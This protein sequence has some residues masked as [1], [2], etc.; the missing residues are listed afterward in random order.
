[1]HIKDQHGGLIAFDQPG[2]DHPGQEGLAGAGCAEDAGRALDE[3]VQVEAHRVPL[4]EGVADAEEAFFAIQAE[5]LGD[6]TRRCQTHRGMVRRDGLGRFRADPFFHHILQPFG[7][8][9]RFFNRVGAALA[10]SGCS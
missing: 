9:L 2:Q 1:M 5:D 4:L 8:S 6:I 10:S 3:F 7:V